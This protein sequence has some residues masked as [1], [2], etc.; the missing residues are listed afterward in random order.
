MVKE[1]Q[2]Q[3]PMHLFID[4]VTYFVIDMEIDENRVAKEL[5]DKFNTLCMRDYYVQYKTASSEKEREEA[6]QKYLDAK[7]IHP[8]FRWS[9]DFRS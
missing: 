6:R 2:V 5:E 7:G 4:L 8:D 1:K 9:K 3:I